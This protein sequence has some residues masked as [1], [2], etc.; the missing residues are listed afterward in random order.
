MD[1]TS[2]RTD[3]SFVDEIFACSLSGDVVL[4]QR[5]ILQ[6][7]FNNKQWIHCRS[8]CGDTPLHVAARRDNLE[9]VR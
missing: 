8:K 6:D 2:N 9:I 4:L 5:V 3:T 7:T 1:A